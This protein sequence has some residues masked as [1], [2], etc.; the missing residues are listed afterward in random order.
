M[1]PL[2]Y[3][4][5]WFYIDFI[6]ISAHH[7]FRQDD[8]PEWSFK[9]ENLEKQKAFKKLWDIKIYCMYEASK[10]CT[11]MILYWFYK[12]FVSPRFPSRWP[13]RM[14]LQQLKSR[15]AEILKEVAKY[16]D[17]LHLWSFEIM[18]IMIWYWSDPQCITLSLGATEINM[19]IDL[20]SKLPLRELIT[21]LH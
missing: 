16:K 6:N 14:E 21:F 13:P 8:L 11:S 19:H 15:E 20:S 1:K 3:D 18:M 17:L 5:Q 7:T 12:H 10:V 2:K 9:S 4:N